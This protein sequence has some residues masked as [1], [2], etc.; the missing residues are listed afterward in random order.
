MDDKPIYWCTITGVDNGFKIK[1]GTV[2]GDGEPMVMRAV[3]EEPEE[4]SSDAE[5]EAKLISKLLWWVI[6]YF[7]MGGSKHD[8][9]RVRVEIEKQK[10]D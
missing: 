6:D 4:Y 1:A 3:L 7:E 10:G 5:R 8:S 9:H 2:D